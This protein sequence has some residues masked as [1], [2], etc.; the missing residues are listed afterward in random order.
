[1]LYTRVHVHIAIINRCVSI[2]IYVHLYVVNIEVFAL[3]VH[4]PRAV[5]PTL[6]LCFHICI[7][8]T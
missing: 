7:C 4:R 6:F 5:Y 8:F 1:M 3:L 2:H